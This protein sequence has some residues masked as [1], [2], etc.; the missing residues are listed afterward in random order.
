MAKGLEQKFTEEIKEKQYWYQGEPVLLALSGGVD[1]MVLL[2]LIGQLPRYL[3]PKLHIAHFNHNLRDISQ[4]EQKEISLYCQRQ[5]FSFHTES[6]SE[7]GNV[8]GNVEAKAREARYAF[9]YEVMEE[10]NI[11]KLLTAH[12][13]DDQ[14]ETILMKLIKGSL[15]ENFQGIKDVNVI[16]GK[17]VIR[18][19]LEFTKHEL[20]IYADSEQLVYWE[21]ASNASDD[22]LRNRVRRYMLPVIQEENQNYLRQI[23]NFVTQ[24]QYSQSVIEEYVYPKYEQMVDEEAKR[25]DLTFFL[26]ESYEVRY[27]IL[28]RFLQQVYVKQSLGTLHHKQLEEILT[29]SEK[30]GE[31]EVHLENGWRMVKEYQFLR[32]IAIKSEKASVNEQVL[33]LGKELD[34][35]EGCYLLL[36]EV[37]REVSGQVIDELFLTE[38]ELPLTLRS[39]QPGDRFVFNKQGQLKKVA[40]YLID[41][42]I[43]AHQR[44]S[45]PLV[46]SRNQR[47]LWILKF[48]KSYLSIPSETDKILYKL[49]YYSKA[50]DLEGETNIESGY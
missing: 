24:L 4:Q 18:P 42:K 39:L 49:T 46:V 38:N 5:G 30:Q 1:S 43:P 35:G 6:W 13:G 20:Q 45:I 27:H 22:Y 14:V 25:I 10:Q 16:L 36:S 47:V 2:K 31:K 19:L 44:Q 28:I 17:T 12:H 8:K 15:L 37:S 41:K 34:L 9:L 29:I 33:V 40:R 11:E 50:Y 26:K 48:R 3:R 7:G 32:L 21:D 23:H